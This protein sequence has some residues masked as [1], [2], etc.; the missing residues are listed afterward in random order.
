M[1]QA[2]GILVGGG[3]APGINGVIAAATIEAINRGHRVYGIQD[4]FHY[5]AAGDASGIRE[6]TIADVSR[7]SGEGGSIIGASRSD[8]QQMPNGLKNSWKLL[9]DFNIGYLV[10]IGGDGTASNAVAVAK[11]G[12]PAL[13]VAHVPKTI[14]ND[15]P[16]P[17]KTSTFG[18][19]SARQ[20]GTE[21]VETL[22]TDAKTM[23]RWYIVVT[24]GRKAGHLALGMGI[25]AGATLTLIPEEFKNG[26]MSLPHLTDIIVAS[27]I[28]RLA[29][30]RPYG[31]CVVAEGIVDSLD[32]A[33][34]A[35]LG[36][37]TRD[38]HGN[39]R[40]T[41]FDTGRILRKSVTARLKEL[42][43]QMSVFDKMIGYELRC[44]DPNPFDREYT[45]QLG[46]GVVDFLLSGGSDAMIT[47]QGDSLVPIPFAE[48]I[49]PK[50]NQSNVRY[51]DTHSATFRVAKKYMIYLTKR[52]LQDKN[53]VSKMAQV[54]N[55]S[56]QDFTSTFK[57]VA[58]LFPVYPE[59]FDLY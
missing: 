28:K 7:I 51:V 29:V 14:D 18:F 15:L 38:P 1:K 31:V 37:V 55:L 13:K 30:G 42:G 12:Q 46:F 49:D 5:L 6:L 16:L 40:Y 58:P 23:S 8:P 17:E 48:F 4:G 24:M 35:H 57:E 11:E 10:T 36:E 39:V 56:P 53:L 21:I 41:D 43:V 59:E 52:D 2:I 9:R 26:S 25:A 22:M 50:T 54:T 34:F 19:Q 44:C 33:S 47:R 27:I 20:V 32:P 3:P 45:R